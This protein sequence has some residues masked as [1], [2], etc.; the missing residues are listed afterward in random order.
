MNTPLDPT[1]L[2]DVN[3][4][5]ERNLF[6]YRH[7]CGDRW[8]AVVKEMEGLLLRIMEKT[9]ETNPMA[10]A[11]PVALQMERDGHNPLLLFAVATEL[12][13]GN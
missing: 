5:M 12:S 10:I 1:Q 4:A 8:P 3:A 11:A 7:I 6:E 9:G 2:D 13:K